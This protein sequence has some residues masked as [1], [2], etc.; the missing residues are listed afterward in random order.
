MA[1]IFAIYRGCQKTYTHFKKGK[2]IIK[3]CNTQCIWITK[4][5]YMVTLAFI[6][7]TPS[8]ERSPTTHCYRNSIQ[9][10][11]VINK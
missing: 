2:K 3:N 5:E 1:N 8:F 9:L 7:L 10:R 4:D 11:K 6:C